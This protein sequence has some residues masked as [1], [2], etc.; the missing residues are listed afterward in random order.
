MRCKGGGTNF[1]FLVDDFWCD[2]FTGSTE[3]RERHSS[4]MDINDKRR[5]SLLNCMQKLFLGKERCLI[6]EVSSFQ[7]ECL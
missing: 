7:R 3:E 6:R 4:N 1:I 2:F 5:V